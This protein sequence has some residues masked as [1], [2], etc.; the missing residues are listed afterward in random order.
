MVVAAVAVALVFVFGVGVEVAVGEVFVIVV[1][2]GPEGLALLL[3]VPENLPGSV[4]EFLALLWRNLLMQMVA[5]L[6]GC[7]LVPHSVDHVNLWGSLTPYHQ[8][9]TLHVV[10]QVGVG[11]QVG[12]VSVA[13][14]YGYH[15]Q[16]SVDATQNHSCHV[17]QILIQL[18]LL[19]SLHSGVETWILEQ[20]VLVCVRVLGPLLGLQGLCLL[21]GP[22]ASEVP[23]ILEL[24]RLFLA[25]LI[26]LQCHPSQSPHLPVV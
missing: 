10:Q 25:V 4:F 22:F 7:G 15:S 11:E 17:K 16:F 8:P 13:T 26:L 6:V 12:D 1:V 5:E 14:L 18:A 23:R 2:H 19:D 21:N 20:L 3:G 24:E 9:W